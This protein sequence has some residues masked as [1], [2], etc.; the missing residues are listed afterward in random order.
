VFYVAEKGLRFAEASLQKETTNPCIGPEIS[1]QAIIENNPE[2]WLCETVIDLLQVQYRIE[3][4]HTDPCATPQDAN[5]SRITVRAI[6]SSDSFPIILQSTF[7][8]PPTTFH[9]D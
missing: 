1:Q 6:K 2:V 7:A 3:K 8:Y 4:L 9:N 5:F